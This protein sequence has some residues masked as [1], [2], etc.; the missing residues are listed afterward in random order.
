M[1]IPALK[2][3]AEAIGAGIYRLICENGQANIVAFGMIPKEFMDIAESGVREKLVA[4]AAAQRGLTVAEI[5][6]H[7]DHAKLDHLVADIMREISCGIYK[8][9]AN[10]GGMVV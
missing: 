9:A 3:N 8:A 4:L 7:L 5:R 2:V 6:P 1:N 10:A